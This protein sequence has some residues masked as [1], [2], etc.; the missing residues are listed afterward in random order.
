MKLS[1]IGDAFVATSTIK[2]DDI[3]LVA[4][5]KPDALK[6]KDKEG[7]DVFSISYV[8]DGNSSIAPFGITFTGK[9]RGED[10]GYATLTQKL[11][12]GTTDAKKY[13]ADAV[14]GV[15]EHVNAIE[16]SLPAVVEEIK[17]TKAALLDSITVA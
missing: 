14:G 17:T 9:S 15:I 5:Y 10:G 12:K 8:A 6:I 11:P 3:A 13:V 2:A 4:K 7:N 16:E 1:V